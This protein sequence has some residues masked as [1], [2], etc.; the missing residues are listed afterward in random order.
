VSSVHATLLKSCYVMGTHGRF[1]VNR[2]FSLPFLD[3]LTLK[4]KA[5]RCFETSG[6]TERPT[7]N[8][9][10]EVRCSGRLQI[11]ILSGPMFSSKKLKFNNPALSRVIIIIIIII[12]EHVNLI[13]HL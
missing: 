7:A 12:N 2:L 9:V 10:P 8:P 11:I 5:P 3:R 1:T 13:T 4:M 6:T